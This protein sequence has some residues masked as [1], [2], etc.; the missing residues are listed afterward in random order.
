MAGTTP[1][2]W[3]FFQI[4]DVQ[5]Q[6][7]LN[8]RRIT[9][10]HNTSRGTASAAYIDAAKLEAAYQASLTA[11]DG[12]IFRYEIPGK[13]ALDSLGIDLGAN[14]HSYIINY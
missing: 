10:T 3:A 5:S 11:K 2:D 9:D 14:K 12:K 13:E 8:F 6:R 7:T 1:E 4:D